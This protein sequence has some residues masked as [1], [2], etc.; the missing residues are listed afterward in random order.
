[1]THPL[2]QLTL[3]EAQV[4]QFRLVDLLHRHFNGREALEAGDY[5]APPGL[6]RPRSTAKVEAVLAEFFHADDAVL[7]PGAGTGAIRSSLMA[8]LDPG[9]AVL[10]HDVPMYA[11]SAV[12]FRA[13]GLERWPVDLNDGAARRV[14][15]QRGPAMVYL[16]HSRT[17]L[18]DAYDTA[19][20]IAEARELAPTATILVDDNYT[21]LQVPRIGVELGADLSAFSLFKLFGEP[22]VGC[23]IGRGDLIAKI[24]DDAYSGGSKIQGPVAIATL[25]MMVFAPVALAVQSEVVT[26]V[27]E[28]LNAGEVAGIRRA[29]PGNHQERSILI[30]L[31]QPIAQRVFDVAWRFGAGPYPVG[32]Q[33]RFETNILIYR[34]SRAMCE[35]DPVL[36][37]RM[38]RVSPFRAGPD[39]VVR[40]LTE[41]I[42]MAGEDARSKPSDPTSDGA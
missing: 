14:T 36:A 35:A 13:M 15:L 6:G 19:E 31:A 33:S 10:V 37:E 20:V 3:D 32:S 22:G 8:T 5:G 25:K 17:M 7:V 4:Y 21:A 27:V 38:I 2:P 23:V 29:H 11:T 30:E 9:A 26:R 40:V 42:A 24:R 39:T 28:R 12:T 41:A 34:L 18:E 16:Q 1:M